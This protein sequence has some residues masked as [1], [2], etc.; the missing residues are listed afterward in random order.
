M[1]PQKHTWM[2]YQ[3]RIA[4]ANDNGKMWMR[5]DHRIHQLSNGAFVTADDSGWHDDIYNTFEEAEK[6][7]S[8]DNQVDNQT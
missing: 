6:A 7:F 5:D 3:Y 1:K 4:N 2:E 8:N